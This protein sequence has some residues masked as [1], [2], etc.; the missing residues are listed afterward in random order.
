MFDSGVLVRTSTRVYM[1]VHRTHTATKCTP[2]GEG[3]VYRLTNMWNPMVA[4]LVQ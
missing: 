2:T 4:I 3:V 1:H